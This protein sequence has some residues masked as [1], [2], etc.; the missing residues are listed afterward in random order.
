M[1]KLQKSETGCVDRVNI[2]CYAC[3]THFEI[4]KSDKMSLFEYQTTILVFKNF[5]DHENKFVVSS[6]KET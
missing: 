3:I 5:K 2:S 4:A 1:L 6:D